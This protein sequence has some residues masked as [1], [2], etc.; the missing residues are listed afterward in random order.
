MGSI[1]AL[2]FF[3]YSWGPKILGTQQAHGAKVA[4]SLIIIMTNAQLFLNF[5]LKKLLQTFQF[6]HNPI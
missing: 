5:S 1:T 2:L 6:I 3:W 4:A